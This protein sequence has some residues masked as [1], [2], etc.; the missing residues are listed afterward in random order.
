[1][2]NNHDKISELSI[3]MIILL[4][5]IPIIFWGYHYSLKNANNIRIVPPFKN[6]QFNIEVDP[7]NIK[8]RD[9]IFHYDID[10]GEGNIN[11]TVIPLNQGKPRPNL[12]AIFIPAELSFKSTEVLQN[13]PYSWRRHYEE[14]ID[15][16][17]PKINEMK[18]DTNQKYIEIDN[19]RQE[20]G[21]L[22]FNFHIKGK[23]IPNGKFT[24]NS[25]NDDVTPL[26]NT[27]VFV[28]LDSKIYDCQS[29]CFVNYG[30]KLT[31]SQEGS[32]L[33]VMISPDEKIRYE[34]FILNTI[35]KNE[36]IAKNNSYA[37]AI[38]L[39]TVEIYLAIDL[40]REFLIFVYYKK[41]S[42]KTTSN[43]PKRRTK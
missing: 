19:I 6:Y 15:Y 29:N 14:S 16:K 12:V 18:N 37:L 17:V 41:L 24:F 1:M 28:T 32:L 36:E 34:T 8:L 27:K 39:L 20:L 26:H 2:K 5:A 33:N 38:G 43:K 42:M 11:F 13:Y 3:K 22:F 7:G 21:N 31:Y 35:N 9:F 23:I 4:I 10:N 30:N 40:F 25:G